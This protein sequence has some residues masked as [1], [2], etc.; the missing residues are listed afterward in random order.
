VPELAV[1]VTGLAELERALNELPD[2]VAKNVARAALRAAAAPV[3]E[4]ARR[5]VPVKSGKLRDSLRITTSLR[6]G[7]PKAFVKVGPGGKKYRGTFYANMIER[8]T[9]KHLIAGPLYFGGQWHRFAQ[10]KGAKKRPFMRPAA[11]S[12][13]KAAVDAFA[14]KMRDRLTKAGIEIPDPE[15]DDDA[16][17]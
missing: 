13:A 16:R 10:H 4:E 15:T 17:D 3:L 2:K 14:A 8:G 9:S 7:V 11:D 5:L 12:Q 6:G 1:N